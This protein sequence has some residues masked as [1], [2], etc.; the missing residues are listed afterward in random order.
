MTTSSS[1][2]YPG[3]NFLVEAGTASLSFA[4][5]S[6]IEASADV[7]EYRGG[8]DLSFAPHKMPGLRR[9]GDITLRRGIAADHDLFAWFNTLNGA[10]VERRDV[11][12]KLLDEKHTPVAT[13]RLAGAW[14]RKYIAG[15]FNAATSAVA[16]EELVLV[17]ESLQFQ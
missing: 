15:P 17:F 3:F 5:V 8:A 4:E 2:P 7:V 13:W 12:I 16:I 1:L 6:G 14:P 11:S 9:M 10:T